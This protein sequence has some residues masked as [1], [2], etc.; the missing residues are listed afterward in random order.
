MADDNGA[1]GYSSDWVTDLGLI[2]GSESFTFSAFSTSTETLYTHSFGYEPVY[3]AQYKVGDYWHDVGVDSLGGT[4]GDD[5]DSVYCYMESTA[6]ALKVHWSNNAGG[7]R[8]ATIRYWIY[9]NPI[10]ESVS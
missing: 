1:I 5:L 6:S 7:E 2:S 9:E 4:P 8:T 10:T 3:H